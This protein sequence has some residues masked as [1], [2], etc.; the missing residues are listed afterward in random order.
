MVKVKNQDAHRTMP[1]THSIGKQHFA[2]YIRMPAKWG[3]KLVVK[4]WT[5]EIV[6]PFRTSEPWLIRLPFHRVL[7]LGKWTG[8]KQDEEEALTTAIQRRE[9]TDDDFT[10]EKGWKPAAYK[11]AEEDSEYLY[12]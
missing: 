4:G 1:K 9:L 11:N 6:E 7:I 3:W 5:Q 8:Y 2:Q 12:S 10:E